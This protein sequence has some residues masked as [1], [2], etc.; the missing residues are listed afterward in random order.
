LIVDPPADYPAA[1]LLCGICRAPA[2]LPCFTRSGRIVEGQPDRAAVTMNRPH[3]SRK[4][5]RRAQF[6]P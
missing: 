2:G 1:Y 3:I 5:S 6:N 4:R